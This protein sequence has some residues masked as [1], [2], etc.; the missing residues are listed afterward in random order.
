MSGDFPKG[1]LR[2][3]LTEEVTVTE[4]LP[5]KR[6]EGGRVPG[7][8]R[9]PGKV[10]WWNELAQLGTEGVSLPYE[11]E[12][13][14]SVWVSHPELLWSSMEKQTRSLDLALGSGGA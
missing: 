13:W 12:R 7:R 11:G 8:G 1:L 6:R 10:T 2:K 5:C 14:S 9:S 3:G 4:K